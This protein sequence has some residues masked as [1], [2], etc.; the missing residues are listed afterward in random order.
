MR[1]D[2]RPVIK[3]SHLKNNIAALELIA[4]GRTPDVLAALD[5][6]VLGDIEG[7]AKTAWLPVE[8]DIALA[9][10]IESVLGPGSDHA[11]SRA[12]TRMSMESTLLK[13]IIDGIQKIFGLAPT[14]VIRSVARAWAQVY[15]NCGLPR[16]EH[17]TGTRAVLVYEGFPPS[18]IDSPLYLKSISGGLHA[19]LDLC[20]VEG[21]CIPKVRDR[22]AGE[23][24]YVFE[25]QAA[26]N[27]RAG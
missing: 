2:G 10:A 3:A 11:R 16:F 12:S 14:P 1:G 7:S 27:R 18:V 5:R 24:E 13:P 4:P 22:A 8:H 9:E 23:V 21:T 6:T 19:C 25:W 15:R 17:G 20:K 26:S